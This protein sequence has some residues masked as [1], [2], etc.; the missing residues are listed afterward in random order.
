[1]Y[2]MEFRKAEKIM[3]EERTKEMLG[4]KEGLCNLF[5]MPVENRDKI[6]I[7]PADDPLGGIKGYVMWRT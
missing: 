7:L 2:Y 6:T 4:L 1:M 5:L 3:S